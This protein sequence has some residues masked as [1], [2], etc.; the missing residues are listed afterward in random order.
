MI[1]V[2][3]LYF[4]ILL[5]FRCL[6]W[7]KSATGYSCLCSH[8]LRLN[9][10]EYHYSFRKIRILKNNDRVVLAVCLSSFHFIYTI[11]A[12]PIQNV[13]STIQVTILNTGVT[14][15]TVVLIVTNNGMKPVDTV[16]LLSYVEEL[17]LSEGYCVI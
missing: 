5:S 14:P 13:Q 1:P 12:P 6:S 15:K 8:A 17:P 9:F 11:H 4:L 16:L 2:I 7:L 3:A 10:L